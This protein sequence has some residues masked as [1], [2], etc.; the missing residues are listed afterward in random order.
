MKYAPIIITYL[1]L[2]GSILVQFQRANHA[3]SLA[4][5]WELI[6]MRWEND[7]NRGLEIIHQYQ[8]ISDDRAK[9]IELQQRQLAWVKAKLEQ[10]VDAGRIR[11]IEA[12]S[13]EEKKQP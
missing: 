9:V 1:V 2:A 3:E 11:Q 4:K 5:R 6:A 8:S 13:V 7:A 10:E 12:W